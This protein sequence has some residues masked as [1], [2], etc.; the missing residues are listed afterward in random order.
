MVYEEITLQEFQIMVY[1]SNQSDKVTMQI[2]QSL[3]LF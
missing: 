3:K 2:E 1:E